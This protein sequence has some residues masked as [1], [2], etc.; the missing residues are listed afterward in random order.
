MPAA[1]GLAAAALAPWCRDR[2][3]L[4]LTLVSLLVGAAVAFERRAA[5]TEQE[6]AQRLAALRDGV[7]RSGLARLVLAVPADVDLVTRQ[8]LAVSC[9]PPL[10]GEEVMLACVDDGSLAEQQLLAAGWR[11]LRLRQG[12]CEPIGS[13]DAP[14]PAEPP[15]E[16][17]LR[18]LDAGGPVAVVSP[19][20]G[21]FELAVVTPAG[22]VRQRGRDPR[23]GLRLWG[24]ALAR[25]RDLVAPLPAG[26]PIWVRVESVEG[27]SQCRWLQARL[28]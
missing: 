28:P 24:E 22:A 13:G 15:W 23:H 19:A 11:G 1:V 20:D 14:P 4:S 2:G 3:V 8:A 7:L 16:V 26:A 18:P 27:E 9:W 25:Y 10:H 12:R 6:R 5:L 21:L 17:E